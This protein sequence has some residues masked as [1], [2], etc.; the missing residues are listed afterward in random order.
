[1]STS[2]D[3][4]TYTQT[5]SELLAPALAPDWSNTARPN[6]PPAGMFG[7]ARE[8]SLFEFY[9]GS[10][11][12]HPAWTEGAI[13]TGNVTLVGG[14]FTGTYAGNHTYSGTVTMSQAGTALSVTNNATIDGTLTAGT[15]GGTAISF[16][17]SAGG[18]PGITTT[19]NNVLF[20][21]PISGGGIA[22]QLTIP[23]QVASAARATVSTT[24]LNTNGLQFGSTRVFTAGS[25][26]GPSGTSAN[27]APFWHN[28]N[29]SGVLDTGAG[30]LFQVQFNDS[31]A[32]SRSGPP[33]Y[34][35]YT[36]NLTSGYDGPRSSFVV[37]VN[38]AVAAASSAGA[39][40]TAMSVYQH[41]DAGDGGTAATPIGNYTMFNPDLRVNTGDWVNTVIGTEADL[42]MYAGTNSPKKTIHAFH[43]AIGDGSH[44][45]PK[46]GTHARAYQ[47]SAISIDASPTIGNG[48]GK[49]LTMIELGSYTQ[50]M[51]WDS[52]A[53]VGTALM[54][55]ALNNSAN[56]TYAGQTY[57]D[58]GFTLPGL[59]VRGKFIDN[60]V[61]AVDGPTGNVTAGVAKLAATSSGASLDAYGVV[62]VSATIVSGG[63][64]A[65]VGSTL[66]DTV[67]NIW[68]VATV[69]GSAAATVTLVRSA[70]VTTAPANPVSAQMMGSPVDV[71]M[72]ITWTA[73]RNTLTLQPSGGAVEMGTGGPS[74]T[75]GAGV[76]AATQPKGSI[77][78]RTGGAVGSTLYVS[79]GGGT[80]NAVA[81]V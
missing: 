27:I 5:I 36:H 65:K 29:Y 55:L 12:K 47:D 80:W 41:I 3:S 78:L 54:Q 15:N 75:T 46:T 22:T 39:F 8:T 26:L 32:D 1:M 44:A 56:M 52:T 53:G 16:R 66:V 9:D 51:P 73:L 19:G 10:A 7:I 40:I 43:Y 77:Y 13:F 38:K 28:S 30:S 64:S 25:G 69:A 31:I 18:T 4:I 6:Q 45:S 74:F 33:A 35:N 72:N 34:F 49:G 58:N 71:T 76:P 59:Y 11:W 48:S 23:S 81:G 24:N 37:I 20:R 67:G 60:G 21:V 68:E 63:S 57:I 14:T 79:Q 17:D 50:D 2:P 61:F 70:S 42:R 62:A